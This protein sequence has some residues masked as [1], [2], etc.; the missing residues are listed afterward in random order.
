MAI[1]IPTKKT[2]DQLAA[3]EFNE[4]VNEVKKMDNKVDK[5]PG[6]GLSSNDYTNEDKRDLSKIQVRLDGL[7]TFMSGMAG[8]LVSDVE[9]RVGSYNVNGQEH[10]IYSCSLEFRDPPAIIGIEKNYMI[11]DTPLGNNMYLATRNIMVRDADGK[12]YPGAIEVKQ[13]EITDNLETMLTVVCKAAIPVSS[14]LLLT[15]EYVKLEGEILEFSFELPSGVD[16]D[17][18]NLNFAPLKYDKHFAFTYTADDSVEGAYARVW[19]R[20]NRKWIDDTEFFHLGN[21]PTT[22]YIP[23]YPLVCTDGCG[24]DRRF[25][26]SIALWPTWGNEYNPD[27]LIKE[28]SSSSIYITWDE[29]DLLKDWGVSFLYHNVDERIHDKTE[30]NAII[31]GFKADHDKV[32]EKLDRRMKI[33]GLPDGNTAYVTAAERSP[34]VDFYRSSLHHQE[35]IYLKSTGVLF[36]K[37]TYG[38]T[39]SSDNATKLAELADQH[40]SDNPYWV[41]ITSH[42]VDLS[43]LDLL[44]TI[45]SLYGKGGDDSIWVAGWDEIY[46][47]MQMRLS[48]VTRKILNGNTITFKIIIP[49]AKNYY[50]KDVSLLLSGLTALNGLTVSNNVFGFSHATRATGVLLNVNFNHVLLELSEKYTSRFERSQHDEDK[51]DALYFVNQ[52]RDD[53][54]APFIARLTI[55]DNPPVLNSISIN[56]GAGVTHDRPVFVTLDVSGTITHYKAGETGNLAG[57]SWIA[58]SSRIILFELSSGYALKTI[59]VQVKNANGESGIKSSTI[60]LV[61]PPDVTYTVEGKANNENHGSVNPA[62]QKVAAGGVAT[63]NAM[64]NEGYV[65]G[66]WSGANGTGVDEVSGSGTITNVQ[67]DQVITCNFKQDIASP[68]PGNKAIIS[69]GWNYASGVPANNTVYDSTSKVTKVRITSGAGTTVFKIYDTSGIEFGSFSEINGYT[70]GTMAHNGNVTGDNSGI[71]PDEVLAKNI[72]KKKDLDMAGMTFTLPVGTYK[73]GLCINTVLK[74]NYSRALY[75]LERDGNAVNFPMKTSYQD[76]FNNLDE[77]T[78]EVFNDVKFSMSTLDDNNGTLV[79]NAIIIEKIS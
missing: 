69:F 74:A 57:L 12:F 67:S 71:V 66:S 58:S 44:E 25:G 72:Y 36:K 28:S 46:E 53:L 54:K 20:I 45:Y 73:F 79:V 18:V 50:F 2:G 47:Y 61:E 26:F 14:V 15:L 65:I 40:A 9:T 1:N 7:E 29:L 17:T 31:K 4:L 5:Q 16:A 13:V 77:I 62:S 78:L 10:D 70:D 6:K 34:L 49:L 56:S 22:G 23:E 76:N 42:R 27:G 43:R 32:L 8:V 35:K 63:V 60:S 11:G 48:A 37:R 51:D 68:E 30:P 59:F 38:G 3:A 75:T 21:S 64:A 41:G 39:N 52:L 24:N 55:N 19:R 33:M